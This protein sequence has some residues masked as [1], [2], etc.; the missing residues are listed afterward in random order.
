LQQAVAMDIPRC[1][2]PI[3]LRRLRSRRVGYTL[4]IIGLEQPFR[5]LDARLDPALLPDF[6][7]V[8]FPIAGVKQYSGCVYW[9]II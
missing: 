2:S 1:L 7:Y 8:H 6:V 3:L 9:H 4:S 5:S